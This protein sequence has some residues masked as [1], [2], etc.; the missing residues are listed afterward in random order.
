MWD[1]PAWMKGAAVSAVAWV[2]VV[3]VA[4]L[5]LVGVAGALAYRTFLRKQPRYRTAR[6]VV[7]VATSA[8]S[9]TVL[10]G[11]ILQMSRL[12][13]TAMPFMVVGTAAGLVLNVKAERALP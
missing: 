12:V 3:D 13:F 9:A 11:V 1:D 10:D 2:W 5:V 8:L 4:V 6:L 7:L